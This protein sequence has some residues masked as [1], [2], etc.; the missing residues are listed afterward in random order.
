MGL[1]LPQTVMHKA[2]FV[3]LMLLKGETSEVGALGAKIIQKR[4]V[5]KSILTSTPIL[6][7]RT[8]RAKKSLGRA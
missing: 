8:C 3:Y 1:G 4:D 6:F 2:E 7:S 5:S